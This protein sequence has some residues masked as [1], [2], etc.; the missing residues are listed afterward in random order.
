LV[1]SAPILAAL[2]FFTGFLPL[3]RAIGKEAW[4]ARAD[5]EIAR[6]ML[7]LVPE[8]SMVLSHNPGM[9]QVMGN[10]AAQTSTATY[11]SSRVDEFFRRFPGGVYFHF[12]FWCNVSDPVQNAFC[13]KVLETYPTQVIE[14]WSAGTYRYVLY[15]LMPR[16]GDP[17][18]PP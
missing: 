3:V 2:Y 5:H 9:L 11:Q 14:E 13:T 6:E 15:R 10:S 18:T 7:A 4:A 8:N 12:N 1:P 16:R 17:P